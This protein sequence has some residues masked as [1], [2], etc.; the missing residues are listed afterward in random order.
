MTIE[1]AVEKATEGGYP[2]HRLGRSITW[3]SV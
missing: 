1:Q 2:Q 3:Y